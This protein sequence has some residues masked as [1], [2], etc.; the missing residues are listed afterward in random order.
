VV[1]ADVRDLASKGIN[2]CVCVCVRVVHPKLY[3]LIYY[4]LLR[5]GTSKSNKSMQANHASSLAK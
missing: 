1:G 2:R 3:V 5:S 4:F